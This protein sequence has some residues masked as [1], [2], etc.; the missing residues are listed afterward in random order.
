MKINTPLGD[1][2]YQVERVAVRGGQLEVHGRLGEWET[3]MV[4]ERSDLLKLARRAAPAVALLGAVVVV[5]RLRG[6]I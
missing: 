3:R 5:T 6:R 2:D 4:V 1:Y